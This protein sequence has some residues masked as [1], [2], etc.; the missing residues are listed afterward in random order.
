MLMRLAALTLFCL[1][2]L[3]PSFAGPR[4]GNTPA[5][6]SPT[7]APDAFKP[8]C[9]SPH[10]PSPA[11][12]HAL[13]IDAKCGIGGN[14][15]G[16]DGEQNDA[17][18]NFCAAGA[19]QPITIE[20]LRELQAKVE[21]NPSINFGDDGA[22]K[23]RDPLRKLGEGRFVT[24]EKAFVLISRQ[25]GKESV[26]CGSKVPLKNNLF[27]DIHVSLVETKNVPLKR[28]CESVVVEM[29]PH[30]RPDRWNITTMKKV[31]SAQAPVRVTGQLFFDASHVLCSGGKRVGSNPARS[32][33]W[34]IHPIYSFEVCTSG[35]GG[36]GKW[37]PLDQWAKTH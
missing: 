18:N 7:P 12:T 30:H 25:E 36:A 3:A 22:T 34:E 20:Q 4:G 5:V 1:L 14:G 37:V 9:A 8:G 29:S 13:G 15:S 6:P 28:E 31:S 2:A 21:Q 33:L 32:S 27:H 19:P 11:P 23:N 10:F 24:I 35:C 26:N 16:A 17:K